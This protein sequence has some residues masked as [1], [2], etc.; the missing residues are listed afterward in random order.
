MKNVEQEFGVISVYLVVFGLDMRIMVAKGFYKRTGHHRP[1]FGDILSDGQSLLYIYPM[2]ILSK[3]PYLP[4]M[5][6]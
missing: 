6:R 1:V 2:F 3:N 4:R 5:C